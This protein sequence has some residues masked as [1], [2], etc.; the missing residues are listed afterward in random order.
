MI[1][2]DL[3]LKEFAS[4]S[5]C[6]ENMEY[7]PLFGEMERAATG[8][9]EQQFGNTIIPAEEPKFRDVQRL[10]MELLSKT[11]DLRV[12]TELARAELAL[13]GLPSF[14]SALGLIR[15]YVE[16]Y[17]GAVHPQLDPDDGNDPA[18]RVNVLESLCDEPKTVRLLR[19]TPLVS[20]RTF[21]RFNLR[22]IAVADGEIT[23]GQG[24]TEPP[25]WS[26]INAAF[27]E[28]SVEEL[29]ANSAAVAS[30][31]EHLNSIQ[32]AVAA[33]VGSGNGVDF[34]QLLAALQSA[35]KVFSVQRARRG[36]TT[37]AEEAA[38]E[39]M[40]EGGDAEASSSGASKR[41]SG[42]I[43]TRDDVLVALQK[44]T[45]YYATYE[46]SSPLPLL[47]QRC[48]RLVSASFLEIIQDLA[49]DVLAQISAMGGPQDE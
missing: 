48:K 18:F 13:N 16:R 19:M 44:I 14:A 21:G 41:L 12:A 40:A 20:S 34:R 47:L 8:K 42:S 49:P 6:G 3:L 35:G 46:P 31:I 43:T 1:D 9:P 26:K 7:D 39:A 17:W 23:T 29:K 38:A 5:P 36:I 33:T 15:G 10:A 45:E 2:M 11:K 30:A 32:Q 4:D 25:D 28:S 24:V 22:D 37:D 27:E